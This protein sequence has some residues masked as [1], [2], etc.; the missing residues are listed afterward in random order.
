MHRPRPEPWPREL[1]RELREAARSLRR[2]PRFALVAILTLGPASARRPRWSASSTRSCCGRSP[3]ATPERLVSI[4]QHVPP[5]RPAPRRVSAGSRGRSS[6][7]AR[8]HADPLSGGGHDD[9][10]RIVRTRQGTARLWGGMVSATRSRCSARA[11]S[12]GR[13]LLPSDESNPTC[14]SCRST[15]G[16]TLPVRSPQS[17]ARRRVPDATAAPADDRRRRDARRLRVPHGADGV[18]RAVRSEQPGVAQGPRLTMLGIVRGDATLEAATG[19]ARR[20]APRSRHRRRQ[21]APLTRPRF[22]LRNLKDAQIK[23]LRPALRV[24]LA[25]VG[26]RPADRVRQRRQPAAGPRLG[27]PARNRGPHRH[28]R[29]PQPHRPADARGVPRARGRRRPAGCALGAVGVTLVKQLATVDAPGIFRLTFGASILPR[30]QEIGVDPAMFA[31]AFGISALAAVAVRRASRAAPVEIQP[32]AGVRSRGSGTIEADPRLRALLVVAQLVMATVLLVGAGLLIHSFG[33]VVGGRPRLRRSSRRGAAARVPAQP[34]DRAPDG[35]DR[36]PVAAARRAR[37]RGGRIHSARRA[38]WRA[39]HDRARSYPQGRTPEEMRAGSDAIVA[40]GQ[41]RYLT[42]VGARMLEGRR[43]RP[44]R[45]WF[46]AGDRDQPRHRPALRPG[47]AARTTRRLALG[48]S[49]RH[50][51]GRRRGRGSAQRAAAGRA[52]SRGLRRLS[53]D[54]EDSAAARRAPLWQPSARSASCRSRCACTADPAS[55]APTGEPYRAR[56]RPGRRRRRHPAA[57]ASR[58][59]LGR[60]PPLLRRAARPSSPPSRACWPRLAST[61]CWPTRS[62][63]ARRKSASAWRS[64]RNGD[65][66]CALILGRG[67][68]LTV[69]GLAARA[70]GGRSRNARAREPAVRRHA[71]RRRDVPRRRAAL[72]SPV[73]LRRT[74]PRAGR[75]AGQSAGRARRGMSGA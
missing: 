31:I 73:R 40:S 27:A 19:E 14:W 39:D 44:D 43:H 41:R 63:N 52:D 17:W 23:E 65:T 20:S 7:V 71:A 48:Q 58:R 2:S 29:Q 5:N 9:V 70:G 18:L 47:P 61:A 74:C 67:L 12:L 37:G 21:R 68:A 53:R 28:G 11:R 38:D 57:R 55:A 35:D 51:P 3:S 33:R 72:R 54:A 30:V 34:F 60:P 6:S 69:V 24:F 50:V 59:Q 62:N 22:E 49:A 25:A 36:R 56:D 26:G 46:A 4:I 10:D 13:T 16:A 42:A 45:R 64:A 32:D 66:C 15:R 8:E 75:H 1:L